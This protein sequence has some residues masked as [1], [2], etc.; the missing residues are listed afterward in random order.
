MKIF[1]KTILGLLILGCILAPDFFRSSAELDSSPST[2]AQAKDAKIHGKTADF[3]SKTPLTV[4]VSLSDLPELNKATEVFCT[5]SAAADAPDTTTSI[6][7]PAD[8]ELIAGQKVWRGDLSAGQSIS[9][10]ATIK[11]QSYGKKIVRALAKR[12]ISDE[13]SWGDLDTVYLHLGQSQTT[14]GIYSAQELLDENKTQSSPLS[15]VYSES[16]AAP[17]LQ[18]V[19]SGTDAPP[20][21]VATKKASGDQ[22]GDQ[23]QAEYA[24]GGPLTV[25]GRWFH[26]NRNGSLIPSR[27][28]L[29]QLRRASDGAHLAFAYTDVNGNFSVGP[30][31]NP[32]SAGVRVRVWTYVK[33][34]SAAANDDELMV[35]PNGNSS[36]FA[37]AYY[38]EIQNN[39]VFPDGT[40]SV[41]SWEITRDN[42]E[43]S[44]PNAHAWY[45][46]DDLD[47]G[48]LYPPTAV[49]DCTVEWRFDSTEGAYYRRGEHVHLTGDN[50]RSPDI[51]LHE[52]G[53]NVMY[54]V[55]GN[56][57]PNT[58]CPSPHFIQSTSGIVC[59]WTEGWANFYALAVNGDPIFTWDSGASLNL[60]T[61]T[62]G[63]SGWQDGPT[64][65]GRVAG[66]L[67][68]IHDSTNDGSDQIWDGF[69]H[70]WTDFSTHF[71]STFKQFWDDIGATGINTTSAAEAV[72]QNTID[73]RSCSA[74]QMTSPANG[75]NIQSTTTFSWST[76]TGNAEYWLYVGTSLGASNI[77]N[78]SQGT[79]TSR[80]LSGLTGGT[81]YVR[82]WSRCAA[83]NV[84]SFN[85]Y[86]YTAPAS[87]SLAQMTSPA[88]GSNIQSSTTF[89]W[90]AG[91][92]NAEYWLYVGTSAG[93][94]NI[95]NGSQGTATSRTVSGMPLGTIYVRLWS[96]CAATNTWSFNDYSFNVTGGS[97]TSA[98]MTSPTNGSSIPSTTT[99]SWNTGN[100]NAEY[101]LYVGTSPGGNN[102]Y[103]ATQGTGTSRT[104]SG[105]PGGT[106][107]VRLWSRC[108]ATNVWSFN[109]YSF[110]GASCSL[111]QMTSPANGSTISSTATFSW[112]TG[113][114]NAE[115]WLYVGTSVGA[116]NLYSATQGTGTS[117][118]ISSLPGGIIYVRLWS[119]CATT[120]VWSFNDYSFNVSGSCSL[121]QMTSPTNGST[122][123]TTTTFSWTTGSGN[124]EYWLYLGTSVGANNLY[125]ATQ[126]TSTSRTVSSLPVG[127]LYVRLWSRCA[128]TNVWSFNDYSY[129]VSASAGLY[130]YGTTGWDLLAWNSGTPRPVPGSSLPAFR[131]NAGGGT[132]NYRSYSL[133]F[134]R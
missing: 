11:F 57:F 12:S 49:G 74:A 131:W 34:D 103:T 82:L 96:R 72:Y 118:T 76:G 102:L 13:E 130:G 43:G 16:Q 41:G 75:S 88:N 60:E 8:A 120:N 63:T 44:Q 128:T 84:W 24:A 28:F 46:K 61:P 117:R 40:S 67:W 21:L 4:H 89:S 123:S 112:T 69:G 81:I 14:K 3:D 106:I 20:A 90:S 68:D 98:Q 27:S 95:F 47:R 122:I 100:G 38:S 133:T 121:A 71:D 94:N 39:Y 126:G 87:C 73:F 9:F 124:A 108:A 105:L 66:A 80:T 78:A 111:A 30:V 125:S 64:V 26:Y 56:T 37:N 2:A 25:T 134:N 116:N 101:W 7:L 5:V 132:E 33:Y 52:M 85:D 107:Y 119:R 48:W 22:S 104:V 42:P 77:Y 58:D 45:I 31:T 55:Y 93:A 35:V 53:H 1:T 18:Y 70:I 17:P 129:T 29:I 54:N 51:I 79:G 62:W 23:L 113:S 36:N 10:S 110:T 83:T 6:L 109:D 99:F 65:E 59:A 127:T 86:S 91:S 115:Y 19:N 97:C 15:G 50:R 92:G 32:G 114:G